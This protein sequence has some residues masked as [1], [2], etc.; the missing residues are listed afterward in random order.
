MHSLYAN[1]YFYIKVLSSNCGLGTNLPWILREN[2]I[3]YHYKLRDGEMTL[4]I[5]TVETLPTTFLVGNKSVWIIP[6]Q[7]S[8]TL[9]SFHLPSHQS[10]QKYTVVSN[11]LK[12]EGE[13][14]NN[15]ILSLLLSPNHYLAAFSLSQHTPNFFPESLVM[16]VL[17]EY[18]LILLCLSI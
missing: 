6:G 17:S 16:W 1:S 3:W 2:C 8:F 15:R 7:Y 13:E 10:P 14:R 5:L 9:N 11:C 12:V 18:F 4:V